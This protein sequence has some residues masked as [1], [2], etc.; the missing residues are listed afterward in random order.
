M[1]FNKQIPFGWPIWVDYIDGIISHP[2]KTRTELQN[3][4]EKKGKAETT[5]IL[6]KIWFAVASHATYFCRND[7]EFRQALWAGSSNA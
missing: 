6:A 2:P 7:K 3:L 5:S 1:W 4:G